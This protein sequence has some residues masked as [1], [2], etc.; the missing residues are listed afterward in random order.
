MTHPA[1]LAPASPAAAAHHPATGRRLSAA[2]YAAFGA[3]LDGIRAR[4]T[5]DLGERDVTYIRRMIRVQRSAEIGGRLA[6]FLGFNPIAWCLGVGL[7]SLSKILDNMEIGHNVMHGQYNWTNDPALRG[8]NFEWDNACPGEQWRHSHNYVHHTF[9]NILGK[10]RD[11]GYG[12]LRMA[13]EQPWKPKH[14]F[15]PV[16]AFLMMLIFE[17]GV[18][19]HDLEMDRLRSGEV[20]WKTVKPRLLQSLRKMGRQGLKDYVIFPLLA[21]PIFSSV[22]LG[23]LAANVIRNIW[24]FVIIFC[25]HFTD[26]VEMFTEAETANETRGEWYVRQL[27]G[28]SNIKGGRWLYILSGHLSHQIEHHLF[29]NMPAHRYA[30]IQPEVEALCREYGLP[31]NTGSLGRQ[32]GTVVRRILRLSLPG[33]GSR[34][35]VAA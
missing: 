5:A 4:V 35:P 2:D 18:A 25:G 9:T 23:N 33:S 15:Q 34:Q 30:E 19:M 31:Y 24:A 26:Q 6:L 14:L 3:A 12:I 29:P 32:F 28:S 27:L 10:D 17:W 21:F 20:A 11:V 1:E 8:K 22:L 13:D 16:R 7:L